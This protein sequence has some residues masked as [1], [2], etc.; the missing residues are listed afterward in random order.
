MI[1]TSHV[2]L[3]ATAAAL[4]FHQARLNPLQAQTPLVS[5]QQ[6]IEEVKSLRK[7]LFEHLQ[8]QQAE[9][10]EALEK[11]L[12]Q[13]HHEYA[14]T[15]IALEAQEREMAEWMNELQASDLAPEDRAL[16]EAARRETYGEATQKLRTT[17]ER[18]AARE[19]ELVQRLGREKDRLR[20][21]REALDALQ[22]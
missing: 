3:Y 1:P 16:A 17:R 15:E 7:E 11:E 20:R 10:V 13:V 12:D 9:K 22:R 21:L 14:R 6:L 19:A 5:Q 4:C 18:S 2:F 8:E